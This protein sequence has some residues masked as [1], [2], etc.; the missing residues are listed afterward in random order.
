VDTLKS[1]SAP[2][3]LYVD[4]SNIVSNQLMLPVLV[5]NLRKDLQ[6]VQIEPEQVVVTA[7]K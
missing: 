6:I 4:V 7:I 5:K 3:E 1:I 2:C